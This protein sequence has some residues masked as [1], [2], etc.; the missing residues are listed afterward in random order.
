MQDAVGLDVEA[1]RSLLKTRVIGTGERLLYWPEVDSTNTL[2]MRLAHERPEEGLVVLADSQTAGKGRQGRH[3]V[4]TPGYHVLSSTLL[5]P[6]FPPHLLVMIASLAVVEAI[7]RVC[8]LQAHIKWPNDVLIGERKVCGILIETCHHAHGQLLAVLGIGINVNGRLQGRVEQKG[9][10]VE[11][12]AIATTLEVA[13]GH[14][15]SR[16]NVIAE[17]LVEIE[18]QYLPLQKEAMQPPSSAAPFDGPVARLIRERWQQRL[19]TLGRTIMVHQG[20]KV[21]EG[22]AEAVDETGTLLLRRPT[23]EQVC[24]A[25]GVVEHFPRLA[26]YP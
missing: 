18:K 3:W 8:G 2:A 1:L 17:L 5:R 7:E 23:G 19:S 12:S 10:E 4:D 22:V 26:T 6:L 21:I 13:C 20:D 9:R 16:E 25:W 14:A 11:L 24:I 15:V